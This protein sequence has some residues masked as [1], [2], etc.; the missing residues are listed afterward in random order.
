MIP[1]SPIPPVE[2]FDKTKL[3]Y[4][5][6]PPTGINGGTFYHRRARTPPRLPSGASVASS[7]PRAATIQTKSITPIAKVKPEM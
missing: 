6:L 2:G 4:R 7:D 3:E 5:R 1:Y